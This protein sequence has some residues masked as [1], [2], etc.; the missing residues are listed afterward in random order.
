LTALCLVLQFLALIIWPVATDIGKTLI[1]ISERLMALL[2]SQVFLKRSILTPPCFTK[3]MVTLASPKLVILW[4]YCHT[5]ASRTGFFLCDNT[6]HVHLCTAYCMLYS[7]CMM[8]N[9]VL[10]FV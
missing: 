6:V 5:H 10:P 8:W 9:C 3:A 4:A 7:C 1:S 2:F